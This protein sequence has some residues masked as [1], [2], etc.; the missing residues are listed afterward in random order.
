MTTSARISVQEISAR[1]SI[2]RLA[3]Y[4][5]LEQ[6]IIPS[7]RLGR[8]W[9]VTRHAYEQWERCCGTDSNSSEPNGTRY[10]PT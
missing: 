6:R 8:R 9:L 4:K 3:V 5:L 1:L 7:L 2:G 10:S